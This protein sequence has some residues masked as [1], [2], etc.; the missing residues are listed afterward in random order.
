MTAA[1]DRQI[2]YA[3]A[4]LD[5]AMQTIAATPPGGQDITLAREAYSVGGLVKAGLLAEQH[6]ADELVAAGLRMANE[7]GRRPWTARE[8]ADKVHGAFAKAKP[9]AVP[10]FG[11]PAAK[12]THVSHSDRP[13]DHAE[14]VLD[15][16]C[17]ACPLLGT[18]GDEYLRNRGA[19]PAKMMTDPPGWP[20]TLRW[21]R[22]AGARPG[23]RDATALV[24]AVN[25]QATGLVRGLQRIFI[26]PDGTPVR[27]AAGDK[28]KL[29]LGAIKGNAARL[30][31]WPSRD[32][33]WGLAEGVETALAA[34]QLTGIPVW[35]AI[36]AG[37]MPNIVP[38]PW[39]R[40]AVVFADHDPAGLDH[41]AK[42]AAAFRA[43]QRIETVRVVR[44]V[45][46]K[47]D[48]ADILE[49]AHG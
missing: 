6:A 11:A 40:H 39:A 23:A 21:S 16:W 41:A 49:H 34:R 4:A 46:A 44:A 22:D 20:E 18:A 43:L 31:C 27:D 19:D 24:V 26:R 13:A 3:R 2:A 30:S 12:A 42:A 37:N 14:R 8:I 48:A 45:D 10:D 47:A 32:G 28:V 7:V 35:S 17:G 15:I 33:R 38:P 29:S 25:D 5:Q 9:R 1:L 36:A